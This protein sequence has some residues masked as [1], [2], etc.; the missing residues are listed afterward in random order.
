MEALRQ[1]LTPIRLLQ[2]TFFALLTLTLALHALL[3]TAVASALAS[4]LLDQ[5]LLLLLSTHKVAVLSLLWC[6]LIALLGYL[7]TRPRAVLML[8]YACFKPDDDR[9]LHIEACEYFVRRSGR[10]NIESE[11]FMR[12]IY[13]RSGLGDE[14][15]APPFIFQTDYEAKLKSAVDEAEEGMFAAVEAVLKKTR[16]SPERIDILIVACGMF[17]P[18]PSLSARVMNRFPFRPSTQTFN[19][20][21]MGCS[22]G[23]TACEMAANLLSRSRK[24]GYALMVVTE[25]I[26]LN[27]YFGDDR[28][29][30]VSNCIFRLGT[31]AV[32]ITND[33]A[34]RADAKMELLQSLTTHHGGDDAS[35][36]VVMQ[37]EDSQGQVGVTLKKDLIRVAGG[38][39]R[40]HIKILAPRVLPVSQL[41]SHG[42]A[43][44]KNWLQAARAPDGDRAK[45]PRMVIPDFRTA[46]EHMCVHAGGRAVV[47]AVERVMKLPVEIL[48]PAMM[49]LHRFGNSS[50]PLLFY[51]LAYFDAKRRVKKGDR[52]WMVSFGAGFIVCSLVW[53]ALR[54]SE[55]DPFNPW[56]DRIHLY[57][58]KTV[59]NSKSKK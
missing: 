16:V 56:N 17:S 11:E 23:A 10:F 48:E 12:E 32:L 20:T 40:D 59:L 39:L 47:E 6:T 49:T 19:L 43:Q 41:V 45:P 29:M 24:V 27:W 46:F 36:G 38:R 8:D 44:L 9:K 54:D 18:S 42:Y 37:E 31:S 55:K 4:L 13:L 3:S 52:M 28:S 50:G 15:Y 21:A 26:S 34:R 5:K 53:K 25:N 35:Y 22:A 7:S 14:T 58:V 51:E 33:P 1:Q 30:L 57:P 2:A